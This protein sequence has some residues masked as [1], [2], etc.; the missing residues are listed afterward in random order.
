MLVSALCALAIGIGALLIRT[1]FQAGQAAG[2]PRD[3]YSIHSSPGR[4]AARGFGSPPGRPAKELLVNPPTA[5][6]AERIAAR[7]RVLRRRLRYA[8]A[9][10]LVGAAV[11][12]IWVGRPPPALRRPLV[13]QTASA[14]TGRDLYSSVA[15]SRTWPPWWRPV[16]VTY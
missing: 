2:R 3:L 11:V 9:A 6:R 15:Y 5:S 16:P 1:F 13:I 4:V 10:G 14:L 8:V 12:V 7:Q